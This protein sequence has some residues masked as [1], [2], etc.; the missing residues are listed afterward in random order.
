MRRLAITFCL[1]GLAASPAQAERHP[2]YR[3]PP[4][5]PFEAKPGA[6]PEVY[7][8]GMRNPYRWSFDPRSGD[9]YVG[10]VGSSVREEITFVARPLVRGANL[11]WS[12]FEGSVRVASCSPRRYVAPAHE[13]R[14]GANVVIGGRVVRAPDL[15]SFRGS[16]IFSRYLTGIHTLGPRARGAAVARLP[17]PGVTAI[18]ED[19]L[20]HLYASTYDGPVHRIGESAGSLTLTSLGEF[21]RPVLVGAVPGDPDGLFVVEKHGRVRLRAGGEVTTFLDLSTLVRDESYEEGL[22][23]FALAPDYPSSG[24][25]FAFYTNN[26]GDIQLDEFARVGVGPDTSS[27]LTRKPLLTIRH[28]G[29]IHYGGQLNFGADGYLYLSTGD[30]QSRRGPQSAGSLLGKMLRLDVAAAPAD[31]TP[32][33]L[34]VRA[35]RSQ[36]V[37]RQGATVAHMRCHERCSLYARGRLVIG[38][39][40]YR[41]RA[42][43]KV[44]AA[45]N[46]T[47]LASVLGRRARRALA[48][49]RGRRAAVRL[50]LYAVDASGNRS[51]VAHRSVA[52]RR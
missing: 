28:R 9:L 7:M 43:G 18:G 25:V 50:T 30:A 2:G 31:R 39:R 20:G 49:A 42:T 44:A 16:Y 51:R 24:R 23:G 21:R 6:R 14:G 38:R 5:N 22:L 46:R 26:R 35:E 41:L 1:L 47:L 36:P 40:S 13:Y 27:L 19:S 45:G 11:G 52:A 4:G 8:L 3:I 48:A 29:S 37:R 15:P 12:C 33:R 34:R 17:V 32:P 10:D